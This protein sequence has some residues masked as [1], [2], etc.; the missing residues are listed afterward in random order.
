M[1]DV[2]ASPRVLAWKTAWESRDPARVVALYA[3]N[4]THASGRVRDLRP[5]LGRSELH[6]TDEIEQYARIAFTR[7]AW[8]RFDLVTVTE[9]NNRAA[10]EYLRHSDV[11]GANPA[12]V[13]ELIEWGADGK[14]S[15]VRVFHS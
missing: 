3:P 8:L 4:A 14:I 2:T 9:S 12:H 11:D 7:F 15:A 10:V 6:G 13:L 5:D 1:P